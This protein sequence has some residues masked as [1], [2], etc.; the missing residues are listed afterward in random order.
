MIV[1]KA[2]QPRAFKNVI[3]LPVTYKNR[4]KG[5]VTRDVFAEW[6]KQDFIPAVTFFFLSKDHKLHATA[7][8]LLDNVPG[9]PK[10]KNLHS[11][12]KQMQV[13]YMSPN[14]TPFLQPLDQNVIQQIKDN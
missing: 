12:V 11:G 10:E 3:Y 9:H 14:T 8:L 1:G 2:K 5:W 13:L 4:T 7:L 6:F